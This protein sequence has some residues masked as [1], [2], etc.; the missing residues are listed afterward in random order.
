[1][2]ILIVGS[3]GQLGQSL[4][5]TAPEHVQMT[6]LDYPEI[7]ITNLESVTTVFNK[8]RP[9][10]V[11]N[12]AAYTAVDAAE[13]NTELA[14][15]VN[16]SGPAILS[17]QC[18][19]SRARLIHIS[20]DFIFSGDQTEPYLPL[21]EARPLS[22]YGK[23]KLRGEAHVLDTLA[24]TAVIIRTAW[25]YSIFGNNFVKTMLR[26]MRTQDALTVVG[27]QVGSPTW[28]TSLAHVVWKFIEN[29]ATHG[30][31][32]WTDRGAISWYDF[33]GEI[34][35]QALKLELLSYSIPIKRIGTQE[36]P[37]AARRPGYSVL[38]CSDTCTVLNHRQTNWEENLNLMLQEVKHNG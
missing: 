24:D 8:C 33:A 35:R 32:H 27:D 19:T 11:V 20:T 1:M 26:L 38:D 34:Q 21:D 6:C 28:A 36:F 15:N 9:D 13:D 29:N 5:I 22:V 2:N 3:Q 23:S 18:L 10:V 37:T 16:S 31:F 25:L 30:I 12:A 14:Y 4:S 7:D 17:K